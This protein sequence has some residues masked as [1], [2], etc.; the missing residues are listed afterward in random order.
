[1]YSMYSMQHW[2]LYSLY[3]T[4]EELY[5]EKD[6]RNIR[7]EAFRQRIFIEELRAEIHRLKKENA[8]LRGSKYNWANLMWKLVQDFKHG[9]QSK[10]DFIE[11]YERYMHDEVRIV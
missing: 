8:L 7:Q 4:G 5:T 6:M 2:E 11:E 3:E 1:M 10:E 9:K